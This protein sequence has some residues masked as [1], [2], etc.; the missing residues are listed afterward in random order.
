[1][2]YIDKT[3]FEAIGEGS[4]GWKINVFIV[5]NIPPQPKNKVI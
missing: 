2:K 1:M 3:S 4:L 5:I